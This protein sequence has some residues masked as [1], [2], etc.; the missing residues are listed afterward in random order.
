MQPR[1][2]L[3]L[4]DQLSAFQAIMSGSLKQETEAAKAA[5]AA[6]G[7]ATELK[8]L[9][10]D[11]DAA[12]AS[13]NAFKQ[14]QTDLMDS[15]KA[16]LLAKDTAQKA[17]EDALAK[18][19]VEVYTL[20][21]SAKKTIASAEAAQASLDKKVAAT[22]ERVAKSLAKLAAAEI[23]FQAKVDAVAAREAAV[24]AK[25]AALKALV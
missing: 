14:E 16:D 11:M 10:K 25:L 19:E 6:L 3:V 12:K 24:E 17:K 23:E 7:S 5:L 1:E 9:Q 20:E 15:Y 22:E 18:K 13:F 8:A 4:A 21:E 2:F